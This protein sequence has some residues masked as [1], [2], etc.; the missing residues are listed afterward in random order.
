MS[1]PQGSLLYLMRFLE[2]HLSA[3]EDAAARGR[4][5]RPDWQTAWQRLQ[6]AAV[7]TTLPVTTWEE[8]SVPAETLAAFLAGGLSLD[9]ANRIERLCWDSPELLRE[10]I[11]TYRFLHLEA[12]REEVTTSPSARMA[13]D[14]LLAIF[15]GTDSPPDQQYVRKLA[16]FPESPSEVSGAYGRETITTEGRGPDIPVVVH[17]AKRSRRLKR[18]RTPVW[19]VY[20]STIVLGLGL[21]LGAVVM[22]SLNRSKA[23]DSLEDIVSPS[24]GEATSTPVE[25]R[26]DSLDNPPRRPGAVPPS[27]SEPKLPSRPFDIVNDSATPAGDSDPSP[28]PLPRPSPTIAVEPSSEQQYRSL[29]VDW[30]KID[31]L[32]VARDDDT[33]PWHGPLADVHRNTAASYATLPGSWAS[34][35][36]NHGRIVLAEDTQVH[37]DGTHDSI[38]VNI[39]RGRVAISEI[40]AD[41]HVHLQVGSQSWIIQP[42]EADTALGCTVFAR[43][44][45]LIV[46]R[47]RVSIGGTEIMAGRQVDLGDDRLDRSSPIQASTLWFS[48]PEI[49]LKIPAATRDGLL[50]SRDVR[51]ELAAIWREDDHPARLL[52]A[53]WSL[54]IGPGPTLAQA[55][56]AGNAAVRLAALEWLLAGEPDDPRVHLALRTLGQQTAEPQMVRNVLS[57]L[58]AARAKSRVTRADAERMVAGLRSDHLAIR[59]ISAFFLETAFGKRVVFDPIAGPAGRQK[60]AREWTML[61]DRIDRAGGK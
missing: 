37:L 14:R 30:E 31:G 18:R 21:A 46:R 17:A 36:T 51:T 23:T 60:A 5:D 13:T 50:A 43:Q 20:A 4:I 29:A 57:W 55:L 27:G 54:A 32:L 52:A 22:I 41:Q 6:L 10:V 2:G 47:G 58:R 42:M 26:Q 44:S 16:S 38:D 3:S 8:P 24:E 59:Q 61:L 9:E 35:K 25:A 53:R 1:E 33:Q 56:S 49:M 15:P 11:S 45:Q 39:E 28:R 7:E 12:P 48:R 34:A 19:L 40:P